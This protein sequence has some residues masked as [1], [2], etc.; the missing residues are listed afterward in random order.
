[1]PAGEWG[2]SP[3]PVSERSQVC[4]SSSDTTNGVGPLL[5]LLPLIVT[6]AHVPLPPV[7]SGAE[8]TLDDLAALA[9]R[10][11]ELGADEANADELD[12]AALT[13]ERAREELRR[14]W[15]A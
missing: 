15:P 5:G 10:A 2:C 13:F 8:L 7:E 9:I 14:Y 1:M 3:F 12:A 6:H 11:C 4:S